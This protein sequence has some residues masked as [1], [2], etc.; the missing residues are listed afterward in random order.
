MFLL[1]H[2]WGFITRVVPCEEF[3]QEVGEGGAIGRS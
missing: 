2:T 3:V 1:S